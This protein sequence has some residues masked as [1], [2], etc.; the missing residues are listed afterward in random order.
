MFRVQKHTQVLMAALLGAALLGGCGTVRILDEAGTYTPL[1]G[2][3]VELLR[4]LTVAPDRTRVFLQRGVVVD[5]RD[6]YEPSCNLEIRTLAST[7]RRIEPDRFAIPRAGVGVDQVVGRGEVRL[8]Q[9]G[10]G[11][12][13][14]IG[15]LA[16]RGDGPS[17]VMY[18]LEM[19]LDSE[20]QPD[21]LRMSCVSAQDDPGRI[22]ML[23]LAQIRA[24][25]GDYARISPP[26]GDT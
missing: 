21:V 13:V 7:E 2:G 4:P 1:A 20:R 12:G 19:R 6:L 23:T 24:A 18:V 11:V 10:I 25:L 8:A 26:P 5:K 16:S 15:P 3:E 14:G 17:Q 22:E 9:I